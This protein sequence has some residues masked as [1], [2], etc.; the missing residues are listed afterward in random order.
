MA[1][2]QF[3][4]GTFDTM[5]GHPSVSQ[6]NVDLRALVRIHDKDSVSIYFCSFSLLRRYT[7]PNNVTRCFV[8]SRKLLY[9]HE[10][11]SMTSRYDFGILRFPIDPCDP[12]TPHQNIVYF[13]I[14][15]LDLYSL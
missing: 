13:D 2:Y 10:V 8:T 9:I 14:D 11:S 1:F 5:K 4:L 12:A 3:L 15:S 7:E 6:I